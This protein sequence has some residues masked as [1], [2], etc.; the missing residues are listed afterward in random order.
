MPVGTAMVRDFLKTFAK[1]EH[2]SILVN[3]ILKL[4]R[5][6]KDGNL[7]PS[8]TIELQNICESLN[9]PEKFSEGLRIIR[10]SYKAVKSCDYIEAYKKGEGDKQIS[11]PLSISTV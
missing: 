4:L 8:R 2:S 6:D 9:N 10:E 1:D 3:S 5:P 11:I 7:K